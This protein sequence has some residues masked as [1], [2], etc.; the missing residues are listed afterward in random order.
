MLLSCNLCIT[1][2]LSLS[3]YQD[4]IGSPMIYCHSQD[5]NTRLGLI[6]FWK[7]K[8]SKRP[9]LKYLTNRTTLLCLFCVLG[10]CSFFERVAKR[11]FVITI[12]GVTVPQDIKAFKLDYTQKTMATNGSTSYAKRAVLVTQAK[13]RG[14]VSGTKPRDF[15]LVI[16]LPQSRCCFRSRKHCR[17]C[18]GDWHLTRLS[19]T[20]QARLKPFCQQAITPNWQRF[21]VA[22][23]TALRS[24]WAEVERSWISN[25]ESGEELLRCSTF[26]LTKI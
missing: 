16:G 5:T 11:T 9:K 18:L 4:Q 15:H 6:L 13:L 2:P 24:Q 8:K 26:F 21:V 25:R 19:A 20:I 10:A 22:S 12:S 1:L 23:L 3:K 7:L 14:E 17:S